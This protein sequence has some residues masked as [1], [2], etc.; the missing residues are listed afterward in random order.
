M[1]SESWDECMYHVISLHYQCPYSFFFLLLPF[2]LPCSNPRGQLAIATFFRGAV[3]YTYRLVG[4]DTWPGARQA[5]MDA[6]KNMMP[7]DCRTSP[8]AGNVAR[9][10]RHVA[11]RWILLFVFVYWVIRRRMAK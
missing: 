11:V 1:V 7:R 4:P 10:G 6:G 2:L 3:P 9:K 8:H 5:I